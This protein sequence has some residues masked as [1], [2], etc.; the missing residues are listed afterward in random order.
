MDARQTLVQE[1]VDVFHVVEVGGRPA[2]NIGNGVDTNGVDR[3]G[4]RG[5]RGEWEIA[6]R[7]MCVPGD[8]KRMSSSS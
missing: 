3:F 2:M 5:K 7:L 1:L 4:S 8:I 6:G